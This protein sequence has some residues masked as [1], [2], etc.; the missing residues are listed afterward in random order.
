MSRASDCGLDQSLY[1]SQFFFNE[2]ATNLATAF[3]IITSI[4]YCWNILYLLFSNP[5]TP[6]Q[7]PE[8]YVRCDFAAN[9]LSGFLASVVAIV[10]IFGTWP[11]PL[12]GAALLVV[13][14]AQASVL[15]WQDHDPRNFG[16]DLLE[17]LP[18]VAAVIVAAYALGNARDT[19]EQVSGNTFFHNHDPDNQMIIAYVL[20]GTGSLLGFVQEVMF[21][22]TG[23]VAGRKLKHRS[24]PN[25]G[26]VIRQGYAK[27][28]LLIWIRQ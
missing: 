22:T 13:V 23:T 8:K 4:I 26:K 2:V 10:L 1:P 16:K 17:K 14:L 9:I 12:E 19:Y 5:G 6:T 7:R 3:I 20:I 18:D 21:M 25:Q 28:D 24:L 15:G 27:W 11:Q